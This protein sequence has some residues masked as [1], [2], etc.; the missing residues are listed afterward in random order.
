MKII[1]TTVIMGTA[2]VADV[3]QI[4]II[5]YTATRG[6]MY[7]VCKT[8]AMNKVANIAIAIVWTIT[9]ISQIGK[10]PEMITF[11]NFIQWAT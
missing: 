11:E 5:N 6:K 2:N 8:L 10:L 1:R 4:H 3:N 7:A 9:D